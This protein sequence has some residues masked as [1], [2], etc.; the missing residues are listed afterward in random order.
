M[1]YILLVCGLIWIIFGLT[2]NTKNFVS[3]LV[4]RVLP[5]FTGVAACMCAMDLMGYISVF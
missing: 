4:F 5:F 2:M 3:A 1:E